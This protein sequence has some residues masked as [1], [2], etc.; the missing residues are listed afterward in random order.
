MF[1]GIPYT[2]LGLGDT[3]Y[4]KFC[5]MGKAIDKRL[6]ELGGKRLIEVYCADEATNL[7]EVVEAW[8]IAVMDLV[9]KILLIE[10]ELKTKAI[11]EQNNDNNNSDNDLTEEIKNIEIGDISIEMID[12]VDLSSYTST[13]IVGNDDDVNDDK[14]VNE[15]DK[16]PDGLIDMKA[17]IE[18]LDLDPSQL[19]SHAPDS[20]LLPRNKIINDSDCSYQFYNNNCNS[21][22]S[23]SN[24][25]DI[26]ITTS[27]NKKENVNWTKEKP[28]YSDIY[29]AK[30]LTTHDNDEKHMKWG[31]VRSVIH[32]ELNIKNSNIQYLPGDSIGICCPN[33]SY[34][35]DLMIQR[36]QV[37]H[38]NLNIT[39]DTLLHSLNN[40]MDD[41]SDGEGD[42]QVNNNKNNHATITLEELLLYEY[43]LS[44]IPKKDHVA[45]LANCCT[46][47]D[48]MNF[49]LHLC[50][51][52]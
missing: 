45:K 8:K 14:Y 33:P 36:L 34:L 7:E 19:L 27:N 21:N 20:K 6:N 5:F 41:D 11:I 4:D 48:E 43:D 52:I 44:C 29:F 24:C 28:F 10:E 38:A 37:S 3:N 22:H 39:K 25:N 23:S 26:N 15:Y 1:E 51:K 47:K 32:L 46:N 12:K 35:I 30:Y 16:L 13:S 49:L 9:N 50:S 31:D 17:C 2:V 40:D 42:D 18:Y